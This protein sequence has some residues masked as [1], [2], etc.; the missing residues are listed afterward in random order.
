[1][2]A[3]DGPVPSAERAPHAR[4][5]VPFPDEENGAEVLGGHG[6]SAPKVETR[7][8]S[9]ISAI[10]YSS[11]RIGTTR[12]SSGSATVFG[13]TRAGQRTAAS[14]HH[15]PRQPVEVQVGRDGLVFVQDLRQFL[16]RVAGE[17]VSGEMVIE[18]TAAVAL[19]HHHRVP[20]VEDIHR[21]A[22]I[23]APAVCGISGRAECQDLRSHDG[24]TRGC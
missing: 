3:C 10:W 1:M 14:G 24:P 11:A 21:A 2:T 6:V 19:G 13:G 18:Q 16:A 7:C 20:E 9:A 22:V 12:T 15:A 5:V 8:A 23:E 17:R 4:A